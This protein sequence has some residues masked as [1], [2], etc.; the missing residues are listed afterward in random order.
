VTEDGTEFKQGMISGGQHNNIF[1]L[2]LG[3]TQL[4]R[5]I[6]QMVN[7]VQLLETRYEALK[8]EENSSAKE[9]QLIQAK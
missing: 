3:T 7:E 1:N 8:K 9:S 6:S 2:T 4:D 5:Q